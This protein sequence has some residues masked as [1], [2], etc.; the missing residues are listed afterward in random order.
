MQ[1]HFA[2]SAHFKSCISL[3]A[4]SSHLNIIASSKQGV[5]HVSRSPSATSATD[6]R[7]PEYQ[8]KTAVFIISRQDDLQIL[9]GGP[10]CLTEFP[11]GSGHCTHLIPFDEIQFV[12]KCEIR[13]P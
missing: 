6:G 9:K 4:I 2:I 7:D 1:K 3:D 8:I 5:K 11:S 13:K 10:C 12:S